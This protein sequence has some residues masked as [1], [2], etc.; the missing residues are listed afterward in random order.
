MLSEIVGSSSRFGGPE[1]PGSIPNQTCNA[2]NQ[3]WKK[4]KRETFRTMPNPLCPPSLAARRSLAVCRREVG[5]TLRHNL[6]DIPNHP[7]TD[8]NLRIAQGPC[9][10]A[11]EKGRLSGRKWYP[12]RQVFQQP[13]SLAQLPCVLSQI[14]PPRLFQCSLRPHG[15]RGTA[16]GSPHSGKPVQLLVPQYLNLMPWLISNGP[17]VD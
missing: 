10:K 2:R 12:D 15:P 4:K 7:Y 14:S 1:R 6:N 5:Q 3:P 17:G 16:L 11:I 13:L 9:L 8:L